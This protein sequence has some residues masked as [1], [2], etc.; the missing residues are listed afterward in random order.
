VM[1][2]MEDISIDFDE[3][4]SRK[5]TRVEHLLTK[6]DPAPE[7]ALGRLQ[8][9]SSTSSRS[10]RGTPRRYAYWVER[11]RPSPSHAASDSEPT[12]IAKPLKSLLDYSATE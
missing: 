7:G 12:G 11:S 9:L 2:L 6:A 10:P 8:T 1:S 4:A 3:A 5:V